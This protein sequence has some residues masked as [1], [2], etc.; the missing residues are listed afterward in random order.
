[1]IPRHCGDVGVQEV[2]FE[3]NEENLIRHFLGRRSYTRTKFYVVRNGSHWAAVEVSKNVTKA[4]F[5]PIEAVKVI[6]LPD[7]TRFVHE[8]DMD[9]LDI[10]AL[11][12][13]Q[14]RHPGKLVVFKG[15]FEHVSFVDVKLPA[16]IRIIDVVPPHP[17]KLEAIMQSLV[18]AEHASLI[19]DSKLVDITHLTQENKDG[20]LIFPCRASYEGTSEAKGRFYLDQAPPLSKEQI[21]SSLLVGCPLSARIFEE[22]Y[23]SKPRLANICV[24][25]TTVV[26]SDDPPTISRCCKVKEGVEVDGRMI[27]V[28]W[29]ANICEVAEALRIALSL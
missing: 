12:K 17:S 26:S 23:G 14:A 8:P 9:V 13:V 16:R 22:I 4:L 6:S 1:M 10:G 7:R 18:G 2:Q 11:L 25:E 28:P 19:I 5:Q 21:E 3:L 24:R 15:R 29:G 27:L 20:V